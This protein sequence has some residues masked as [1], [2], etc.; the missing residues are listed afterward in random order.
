VTTRCKKRTHFPQYSRGGRRG[1]VLVI[2]AGLKKNGGSRKIRPVMGGAVYRVGPIVTTRKHGKGVE[3]KKASKTEPFNPSDETGGGK[4]AILQWNCACWSPVQKLRE[5][6]KNTGV[7]R[8]SGFM[9]D[10]YRRKRNFD[11]RGE[12]KKGPTY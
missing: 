12:R 7:I 4:K 10:R 11:F 3:L 1:K 5:K 8:A 2:L 6:K 9:P